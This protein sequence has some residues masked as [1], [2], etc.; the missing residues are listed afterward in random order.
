MA[1]SKTEG[2]TPTTEGPEEFVQRVELAA[3]LAQEAADAAEAHADRA[4]RAERSGAEAAGH[5]ERSAAAAAAA[6]GAAPRSRA[7]P[8]PDPTYE[9]DFTDV[10]EKTGMAS[11][12]IGKWPALRVTVEHID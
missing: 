5:A 10:D 6:K 9:V 4:E 7:E 11:Q 12:I 1:K 2:D 8:L 3:R